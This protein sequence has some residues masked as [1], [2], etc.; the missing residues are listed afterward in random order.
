MK[1][2]LTNSLLTSCIL[3]AALGGMAKSASA[4]ATEA[5]LKI[6]VYV[7]NYAQVDQKT[8]TRAMQ[9]TARI[10][11][12]T[13]LEA[14]MLDDPF[15]TENTAANE[16]VARLPRLFVNIL[17]RDMAGPLGLPSNIL[18][19]APGAEDDPGYADRKTV[20]VFN[21]IA[22]ELARQQGDADQA[23]LLGYAMAHEIGHVL[24]HM[25]RHSHA[26]I[27]QEYWKPKDMRAMKVGGLNFDSVQA[28][29]LRSEVVRRTRQQEI[30]EIAALQ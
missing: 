22:A 8:L 17:T 29:Q 15:K 5:D 23:Y 27:M 30:V 10:F 11:H 16:Q 9:I 25:S 12:N 6:A 4:G 26:G 24:L 28:V 20:Y 7:R 14:V 18:G 13:G 21:H 2:T 19:V 1:K 3:T